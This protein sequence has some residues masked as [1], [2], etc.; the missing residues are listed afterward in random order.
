MEAWRSEWDE[1]QKA[2]DG[3]TIDDKL[4]AKLLTSHRRSSPTKFVVSDQQMY[5]A[6]T[7]PALAAANATTTVRTPPRKQ[8]PSPQPEPEPEWEQPATPEGV[9]PEPAARAPLPSA[10]DS[11]AGSAE[12]RLLSSILSEPR[13]AS[14]A[15]M[16]TYDSAEQ[17]L[18]RRTGLARPAAAAGVEA[19]QTAG[20]ELGVSGDVVTVAFRKVY[21]PLAMPGIARPTTAMAEQLSRLLDKSRAEPTSPTSQRRATWASRGW[22]RDSIVADG[23]LSSILGPSPLVAASAFQE[24]PESEATT[25][26]RTEKDS[27]SE[28]GAVARAPGIRLDWHAWTAAGSDSQP[29]RSTSAVPST[30]PAQSSDTKAESG[31]SLQQHGK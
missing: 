23:A 13:P 25:S 20:R 2:I 1:L 19:T 11:P 14:V 30:Q 5:L 7:A 16:P 8:S 24:S 12:H 9:P 31:P 15:P 27:D 4:M 3:N 22:A 26:A 6:Q 10:L 18:L 21:D 28:D 29:P 17:D